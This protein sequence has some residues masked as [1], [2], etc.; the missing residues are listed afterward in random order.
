MGFSFVSKKVPTGAD[1]NT[2][3][4]RQE[5]LLCVE[6]NR[7]LAQLEGDENDINKSTTC[8]IKPVISEIFGIQ[9]E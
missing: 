6:R 2:N 1:T 9:L 5:K 7:V 8:T 4:D 3:P